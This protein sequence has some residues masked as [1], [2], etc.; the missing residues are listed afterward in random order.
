VKYEEIIARL[1]TFVKFYLKWAILTPEKPLAI[2][3]SSKIDI[4]IFI[5]CNFLFFALEY[6][7]KRKG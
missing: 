2:I 4:F 7:A 5:A 6:K 3:I 1:I